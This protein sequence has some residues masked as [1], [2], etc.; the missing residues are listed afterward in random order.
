MCNDRR[1]EELLIP[2][3]DDFRQCVDILD[4][5]AVVRGPSSSGLGKRLPLPVSLDAFHGTH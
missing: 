5:P 1:P 2:P 3:A 4:M